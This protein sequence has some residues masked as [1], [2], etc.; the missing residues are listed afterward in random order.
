[1]RLYYTCLPRTCTSK[2][3]NK[4]LE[5]GKY[6]LPTIIFIVINSIFSIPPNYGDCPTDADTFKHTTLIKL[7]QNHVA[8]HFLILHDDGAQRPNKLYFVQT[9]ALEYAQRP[10]SRRRGAI[11]ERSEDFKSI[12]VLSM[13][14]L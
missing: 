9:S 13:V 10:K 2:D 4:A 12:P 14:H 3:L 1:M 8:I 5:K 7:A 6:R 11:S